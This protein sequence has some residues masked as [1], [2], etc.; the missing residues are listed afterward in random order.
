MANLFG[1]NVYQILSVS[2]F[3]VKDMTKTFRYVFRF[4][5]STAVH[6]QSTNA[7]FHQIV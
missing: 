1:K 7:E 6:L 3:S 5:V 4:R 2:A